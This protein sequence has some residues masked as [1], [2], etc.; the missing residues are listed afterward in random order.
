MSKQ[1]EKAD[2]RNVLSLE[3]LKERHKQEFKMVE[4]HVNLDGEMLSY[5]M[6]ERFPQSVKDKYIKELVEFSYDVTMNDDL[7]DLE[8]SITVYSIILIIDKFTDLEIPSD[9]REKILYSE[10]LSDFGILET[11]LV[12]FEEEEVNKMLEQAEQVLL[13]QVDELEDILSKYSEESDEVDEMTALRLVEKELE[14]EG[15]GE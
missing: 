12:A 9:Y 13:R 6:Y 11:I 10:L 2:K 5:M 8:D 4:S 14:S 15:E 3:N 7:K 1:G